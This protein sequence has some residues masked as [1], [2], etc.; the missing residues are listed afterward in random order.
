VALVGLFLLGALGLALALWQPWKQDSPTAVPPGTGADPLPA[1]AVAPF[2]ADRAKEY[3][4]AWARH[5][6][7]DV[8]ITN[9][10]GMK[11]RL[12]P[13]GEFTMGSSPEEIK[14]ASSQA[15]E[16]AREH[17]KHESPSRR[18]RIDSPSYLG[19]HEVTVAEFRKFVEAT[20][21]KTV[22]ETDGLGSW[23]W[24]GTKVERSPKYTWRAPMFL[25]SDKLPVVCIEYADAQAFCVWLSR[26][27]G[28]RYEI[29]HEAVWEFACRAGTT[30]LWPW[31]DQPEDF[32]RFASGNGHPVGGKPANAFGLHDMIGNV[33]EVSRADDRAYVFRGGGGDP[34]PWLNRSASRGYSY[35]VFK[36]G[37]SAGF[38][39]AIVGDLKSRPPSPVAAPF[40]LLGRDGKAE[41]KFPTLKDAVEKAQSG[42]TIEI[43]GD[44]PF[45]SG[46]IKITRKALHIRAGDGARPVLKQDFT[47]F[48]PEER[49]FLSHDSPL[50][51]E[52]LELH[53]IAPKYVD[54]ATIASKWA[55]ISLSHCRI[56]RV[57]SHA[58]LF[59]DAPKVVVRDC[60]LIGGVNH[61]FM[62]LQWPQ[63]RIVLENNIMAA[64]GSAVALAWWPKEVSGNVVE[65]RNNT[66]LS[67]TS[68]VL[69]L[70]R[71]PPLTA[72]G[73]PRPVC[74]QGS[75]NVM[76][77]RKSAL[78][79]WYT[80]AYLSKAKPPSAVDAAKELR[81]V[82]EWQDDQNLFPSGLHL[83]T[84][85][86]DE[87]RTPLTGMKGTAEWLQFWQEKGKVFEGTAKFQSRKV[88]SGVAEELTTVTPADFRLVRGS[89]GQGVLPGGKDLGADVEKVGPGKPYEEWKKTPEY[90]KWR[91]ETDDL[92]AGN[93]TLPSPPAKLF[94]VLP[95]AGRPEQAFATLKDAV[96]KAESGDT[97][98]IHGD[99]PFQCEPAD[100]GT[101]ALCIRASDGSRPVLLGGK[102]HRPTLSTRGPL[103]LEGLEMRREAVA[104]VE[105]RNVWAA[106]QPVRISHCRFLTAGEQMNVTLD[107]SPAAAIQHTQLL[108]RTWGCVSWFGKRQGAVLSIKQSILSAG[109]GGLLFGLKDENRSLAQLEV[110]FRANTVIGTGN[111][112]VFQTLSPSAFESGKEGKALRLDLHDNLVASHL[113]GGVQ[114][115][116]DTGVGLE[117][118]EAF[119][120]KQVRWTGTR[121]RFAGGSAGLQF[122]HKG[123]DLGVP[124]KDLKDWKGW[125]GLESPFEP[126]VVKFGGD[127][128]AQL[129][130]GE[131]P[132]PV[133]FRAEGDATKFGADVDRVGPGKPYEEWKKTEEYRKW[134]KDTEAMMQGK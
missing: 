130:K 50:V 38:R 80:P 91:K 12:I 2:D 16:Y 85:H 100:A 59:G 24:T 90:E 74:I 125:W 30:G 56:L 111:W 64:E 94:N 109:D 42:D 23:G 75:N 36:S 105:A 129:E 11:L 54:M 98:E 88:L 15:P 61:L 110:R 27:D 20:G 96:E 39:V 51:L 52:G 49:Y 103:V 95:R 134:Q 106:D 131:T 37:F 25:T 118:M 32:E 83:A 119:L 3:Q 86:T 41:Q 40:V 13:P 29:P 73:Q 101:K 67:D 17:P 26:I 121:N 43:R 97:I 107:D 126:G 1:L 120:R 116:H 66:L 48:P 4:D 62:G 21:H 77:A 114:H 124:L 72:D 60:E 19:V 10:I 53:Q 104:A 127:L 78:S 31:G 6:G 58:A 84:M 69:C 108:A 63:G 102:Q 46:P 5:L 68:V 71:M 133:A 89:P 33:E 92:V 117:A 34:N 93:P 55:P 112:L 44:G 70:D 81:R 14:R 87:A 47:V 65:L 18:V 128:M 132:Q 45:V 28:R 8:E 57:R 82:V 7:V 113:L 115:Q 79:V 122:S 35:D 123:K 99:G 22:P 9:A 76:T